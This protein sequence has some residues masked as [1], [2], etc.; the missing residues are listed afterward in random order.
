MNLPANNDLFYQNHPKTVNMEITTRCNLSCS[1]CTARTLIKNP[2]D[3]PIEKIQILVD[4]LKGF[5]FDFIALCG[6]GEPLVHRNFYE[7]LEILRAQKVILVSNGSVPIDYEHLV[8]YGNVHIITISVDAV[9]E[10]SL[11]K[12]CSK[13]NYHNLIKNLDNSVKYGVNIAF[14][15]TLSPDNLDELEAIVDMGIRYKIVL[16]KVGLPLGQGLWVKQNMTTIGPILAAIEEK[17]KKANLPYEG[18]FEQ[19]CTYTDAPTALL[20]SSGDYYPCCDYYSRRPVAGNLF[21][22]D[23]KSLWENKTYQDFRSGRFCFKC[24]LYHNQSHLLGGM[25]REVSNQ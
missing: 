5:P 22:S 23:L 21:R 9:T 3:L 11:K 13:Y 17:A 7:I 25:E 10:E 12:I 1:Y 2:A 4:K 19:K 16:L 20:L 6:M 24:K 18:P 14:N 8:K 15:S